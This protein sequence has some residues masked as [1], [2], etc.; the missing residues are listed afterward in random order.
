MW[1]T[2]VVSAIA[3]GLLCGLGGAGPLR[4]HLRPS[5]G[6][7]LAPTAI[8]FGPRWGPLGPLW[9]SAANGLPRRHCGLVGRLTLAPPLRLGIGGA[10]ERCRCG[11][12]RPAA[13]RTSGAAS[14]MPPTELRRRR[15]RAACTPVAFCSGM[16]RAARAPLARHN[17]RASARAPP[18]ADRSPPP[19]DRERWRRQK[20]LMYS[21]GTRPFGPLSGP[22]WSTPLSSL[23]GPSA[24]DPRCAEPCANLVGAVPRRPN[25][26]LSGKS[27]HNAPPSC[28]TGDPR[29][30][31][32]GVNGRAHLLHDALDPR[33]AEQLDGD[34]RHGRLRAMTGAALA[35]AAWPTKSGIGV[36]S[37]RQWSAGMWIAPCNNLDPGWMDYGSR[38]E[39]C[40]IGESQANNSLFNHNTSIL[41]SL[42][43]PLCHDNA[44]HIHSCK[45]LCSGV[46]V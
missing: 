12:F 36:L 24:G 31:R 9:A 25:K 14:P 6:L 21:Q 32:G 22:M 42:A 16:A 37:A 29:P 8:V 11:V 13:L 27:I 3:V 26:R 40:R 41:L 7:F 19:V 20:Q 34:V 2:G 46:V 38:A 15:S 1:L 45:C 5:I 17:S 10:A 4:G 30:R 23:C 43:R 18:L 44:T 35:R 33:C 28:V 39:S